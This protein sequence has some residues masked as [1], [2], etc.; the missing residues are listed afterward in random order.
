MRRGMRVGLSSW[1]G[2]WVGGWELGK[3]DGLCPVA[4]ERVH[5]GGSIC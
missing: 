3:K 4:G 2:M 1:T 5:G